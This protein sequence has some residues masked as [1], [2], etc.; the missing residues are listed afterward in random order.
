MPQEEIDGVFDD[1]GY[2]VPI[3]D[4]PLLCTSCQKHAKQHEFDNILCKLSQSGVEDG[5]EFICR[6][7]KKC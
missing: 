4:I 1:E 7:Y 5:E 3:K 2:E 6:D